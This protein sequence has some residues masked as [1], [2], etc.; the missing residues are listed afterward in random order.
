MAEATADQVILA[1]IVET[2]Y[3][4]A[5]SGSNLQ[6]IR[7]TGEDLGQDTSSTRSAEIR[8]DRQT[9]DMIRTNIGA[10]GTVN[11]ELNLSTFSTWLA[12][13]LMDS[14]WAAPLTGDAADI[15]ISFATGNIITHATGFAE[16][17]IVGQWIK[18]SGA[19]NAENNGYFK[20]SAYTSTQI[21]VTH[22]SGGSGM[23]NEAAGASVTIIQGAYIENGTTLDTYNIER[24]YGDLSSELELLL[25][26]AIDTMSIEIS[27]ENII[28]ASFGFIGS[29]ADSI[30]SSNGSGYDEAGTT[31][32]AN[33][34]EDV[35]SIQDN[36]TVRAATAFSLN[37]SNN[38][39]SRMEI[40]TLG[41]VSLG[42]GKISVSGSMTSYYSSKAVLDK[43]IDWTDSN[44]AIILEDSESTPNG[45]IIYLP[46]VK[47]TNG[48]RVAGGENTDIM[49]AVDFEAYRDATE[50]ITIRI[51][52]FPT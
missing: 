23:V 31:S 18:V 38:L 2:T 6:K 26:M 25:G 41:A 8:D 21:T 36:G 33:A 13:A 49:G 32:P 47:Y 20:V 43:Y 42:A 30:T 7:F 29:S 27:P 46:Q 44:L 48:R 37:L 5:V 22:P 28:T 3:K 24:T 19:A 16:T 50:D 1:Y 39:R 52:R 12:S 35:V 45:L 10:S 14:A 40:G 9:S 17:Y 11:V 34:V 4:T 51:A 15:D